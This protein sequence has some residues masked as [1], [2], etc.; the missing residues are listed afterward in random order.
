[1]ETNSN[2]FNTFS[3]HRLPVFLR[4]YQHLSE[5]ILPQILLTCC[6]VGRA[7]GP[8]ERTARTYFRVTESLE[9]SSRPT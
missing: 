3:Q 4:R 2:L 9:A 5:I 8:F 1:M 7:E 6:Q